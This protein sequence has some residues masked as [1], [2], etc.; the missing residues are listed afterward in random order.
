MNQYVVYLA[1]QPVTA[2]F[3]R[4]SLETTAAVGYRQQLEAR[5]AI[6][7]RD[8]ESRKIHVTGAV[9][10][11]LNA[12]FIS[13][14]EDRVAEVQGIQ[15]VTA[16]RILPPVK[17]RFLNKATAAAGAPAAWSAVGGQSNAGAGIKIAVLDTGI[18]QNHPS[19]Q[20]N[21]LTPPAGFPKCTQGHPED[22]SYTNKKVIVARSY[23][24]QIV[25][26]NEA[27]PT[28]NPA[29][30][31]MPDDYSPRDRTGHG[32]AIASAAAGAQINGP[33]VSFSGMAPK[34]FL[35]NYK[36][37]GT[38]GVNDYPSTAV[39]IQ[40]LNDAVSDGMDV[41]SLSDG[42][43]ALT[44][45]LSQGAD[46]GLPAAA[47]GQQPNYCDPLAA[48]FELA[49]QSG[50][51]IALAAGNGGSDTY[52]TNGTYPTFNS[53]ISPATAPSALSV[54]ATLNTHVMTPSVS[55]AASGA[56]SSL[57]N[58]PAYDG[59]SFF[60]VGLAAY[61]AFPAWT[62]PMIDVTS[63]GDNGLA[64]SALPA[65]SLSNAFALIQ[66]GTCA[67]STKTDNA[68]AAGAIGVVLVNNSSA[69]LGPEGNENFSGPVVMISQSAGAA[70]QTY[71]DANEGALV[72]I[73]TSGTETDLASFIAA[74]NSSFAAGLT[75]GGNQ[76]ASYSS[77]G[78]TPD[79]LMKPDLVTV[80][81]SDNGLAVDPNDVYIPFPAG[82]YMATQSFDPG[83]DLYSQNGFIS[84]NGTSFATPLV[85][86]AA[87]L[88]KQ[89]HPS[90]RGAQV[91]S[92]L[93]NG[94]TQ[95]VT[96]DDFGDPVDAE[97]I[98][99]GRLNAGASIGLTVTAE[100]ATISFGVAK[101]LPITKTITLTNIGSSSVTLTPTV[102]CCSV[103]QTQT[104]VSGATVSASPSSI[105]IAAGATATLTVTLSGTVPAA[106]SYSGSIALKGGSVSMSI[107]F[108]Y[109]VGG[110]TAYNAYLLSGYGF[111]GLAGQDAGF[112][113]LQVTDA[114]GVP[115]PNQPM[116]LTSS[117]RGAVTFKS[118]SGEPSCSGT[119][120]ITCNTDNFGVA[121]AEVILGSALTSSAFLNITAAG[122]LQFQPNVFVMSSPSVSTI[123]DNVSGK[124]PIAPGSWVAI[125]GTNLV[126]P[127]EMIDST[128]G[129]LSS[130]YLAQGGMLPLVLDG[131]TVSFDVPG[132][133]ISVP[134]YIYYVNPGQ[135]NVW[136][137]WELEGQT[138]A[139][140]KVTVDE[141]LYG[142]VI[143][144]PLSNY[145]P[146][147]YTN[148]G[149]IVTAQNATNFSLITASNPAVQGQSI[150]LYAN[151][152]GPV[153]NQPTSGNESPG[154]PNLATTTTQP[155]VT[156]GGKQATVQFSG[157][158]PGYVGLY[159]INVQ[160]PTGLTA[161]NQPI[162][163]TIGGATSPAQTS[164]SSPQTIV[165]PVK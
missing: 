86:G 75:A 147:L 111:E 13:T 133:G 3:A 49:A 65:G 41:I 128:N 134:G 115:V 54:G 57:K 10:T 157:L 159:Q 90:L 60:P 99:A 92:L 38:E 28:S 69:I 53:I 126:N 16:V 145:A 127:G 101:S 154:A 130:S 61:A 88:I 129:D 162:T 117:P 131:T 121:Y 15:G 116:T 21:S 96:V 62:A 59:D 141:V 91:K 48:G 70:L 100:P 56:S 123:V 114:Y 82:I 84:A 124:Q 9:T 158:T 32:T 97:W 25:A 104:S 89:A 136:V 36:I 113:A 39:W 44:G 138:S 80:G 5:Q 26:G 103:N 33:A 31:S 109:L 151:G 95:D 45:A 140:M 46:C 85:A 17:K 24:R 18:D 76:L 55:V 142:N 160:V 165:I 81:G 27:N 161:G 47:S 73:D 83:G 52:Y 20:D 122:A 135:V 74:A 68:Q 120:T 72:T 94:A 110:T 106:S 7:T 125:F 77:M 30:D 152:M 66:R 112:I 29:A 108:L 98:G 118:V 107:P 23:V 156:I 4:E 148:T 43:P 8:L 102:N 64:C 67:F 40:A 87:A 12:L 139:Q 93:V 2:R 79:G 35:G 19:F 78:P 14:T 1:D 37:W 144:V 51:V 149:N 105:T 50:V 58:I 164:G 132:K 22:C 143:T 11:L 146:S 119:T 34:A 163:V 42:G 6:V 71:I 137:P 63:T 150:V 153:N 155:V